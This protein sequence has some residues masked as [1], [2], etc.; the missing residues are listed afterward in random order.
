MAYGRGGNIKTGT[1]QLAAGERQAAALHLRKQGI[2]YEEIA[3]RLGY[4]SRS[5]AHKAVMAG[6]RNTLQE[7]ADEVRTLELA[8]L[9]AIVEAAWPWIESGSATHMA[10]AIRAMERRAKLLG[11]D[12]PTKHES[13]VTVDVRHAAERAAAR[14]DLPF[15]V[16]LSE[17]T[18]WAEDAEA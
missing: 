15:D 3:A 8:R 9:D 7:P 18:R 5:G 2:G 4:G 17:V 1:R 10:A 6:L 11:L 13:A 12:A 16:V 14:L